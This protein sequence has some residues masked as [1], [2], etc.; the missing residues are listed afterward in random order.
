MYIASV[1]ILLSWPVLILV[2]Y[3]VV[4]WAVKGYE[5]KQPTPEDNN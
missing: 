1:L 2:S 4:S 5:K 3:L